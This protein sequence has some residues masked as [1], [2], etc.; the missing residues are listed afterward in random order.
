MLIKYIDKK[1]EPGLLKK[2]EQ[3]NSIIKEYQKAGFDLTLRQLYYQFVARDLIPNTLREYKKLGDVINNARL[4]GLVSWSAIVDRTRNL[5]KN[6]HWNGPADIVDTCARSF[7]IDKWADQKHRVEVWVEKDA[8]IGVVEQACRPL[9]VSFFSCRGYTSQSEMWAAGQRLKEFAE[10][11]KQTPVIIHLGDH[12][13]SGVDMS[14]DIADRLELFMGGLEVNRI[15]LNMDQVQKYN[16]PP[17]PAKITD[18]RAAEYIKIHG[19]ESWELDALDPKV[20]L[21]LIKKTVLSYRDEDLWDAAVA[22][23][24]E[25]RERLEALA[26]E[27]RNE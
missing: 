14:R 10:E 13:P 23:Q 5:Q 2:I 15:A 21:A 27:L 17:N 19:D 9:D 22:Q 20:L 7:Q 26:E 6:S 8:L 12:D 16:P 11:H 4:A 18:S 25:H 1:F 24:D 3:A